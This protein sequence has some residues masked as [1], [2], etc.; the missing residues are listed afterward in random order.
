MN[1]NSI[2]AITD[3]SRFDLGT[4]VGVRPSPELVELDDADPTLNL[5]HRFAEH[6][7]ER[8]FTASDV[9]EWRSCPAIQFCPAG[10]HQ[11]VDLVFEGVEFV[12]PQDLRVLV[13]LLHELGGDS[14]ANFL[15]I[16]HAIHATGQPLHLLQVEQIHAPDCSV[17]SGRHVDALRQQA[18][19][20]VLAR[21]GPAARRTWDREMAAAGPFETGPILASPDLCVTDL[22]LGKEAALLV[23]LKR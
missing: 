9:V 19:D 7:L 11:G 6:E 10:D 22:M 3:T 5:D 2:E 12:T 1:Q 23:A 16:H 13:R 14:P 21:F 20:E 15:R 4:F 17:Y 8:S 18:E